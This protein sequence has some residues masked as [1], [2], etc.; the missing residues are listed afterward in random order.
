MTKHIVLVPG[1]WLGAWAWDAVA[2]DL[3]ERGNRVTAVTL[4]GLEPDADRAGVTLADQAKAI[5]DIADD[6]SVLVAHSGG[7]APAY[8]ATDIAPDRFARVIYV[9][10][11]PLADGVAIN[12]ELDESVTEW[13]LPTWAE[14][15]A[16]GN[17]LDGLDD[18]TLARIRERSVPQPALV[19]RTPLALSNPAR[20]SVPTTIV[21]NALPSEVLL[22]FRDAGHPMAQE[23]REIDAEYIDL[24]TSHW[25][26]FSKPAELAEIIDE[27]ANR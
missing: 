5:L 25:P 20:R 22:Q 9:D 3:R 6:G 4:P 18:A 15:E 17:N 14:Q 12:A 23:L 24:P 21:C 10:A 11:G 16:S 26:M 27:V 1:F 8:I 13:P 2:A 7:A 19:A